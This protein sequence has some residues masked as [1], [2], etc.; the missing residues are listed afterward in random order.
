VY[1]D[2]RRSRLDVRLDDRSDF[3]EDDDC[4]IATVATDITTTM[5]SCLILITVPLR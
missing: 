1:L 2:D 3:D 4:A 5:P